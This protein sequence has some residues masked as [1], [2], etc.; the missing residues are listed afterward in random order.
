MGLLGL[1]L[2]WLCEVGLF[3]IVWVGLL[4]ARCVVWLIELGLGMFVCVLIC[5]GFC[6]FVFVCLFSL[7]VFS[8]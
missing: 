4:F 3:F 8:L 6:W 1:C 2:F 7:G 5:V